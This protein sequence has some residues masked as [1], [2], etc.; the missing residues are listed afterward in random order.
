MA[1]TQNTFT[2][3][4][5]NLGPFSFTFK[6]L[7]PTDVKVTVGGVLKT[8]GTHYNLQALNY[9]TKDGGQVLFT[10]GNAPANNATIRV[11]RDTDDNA[12][13]ATFFS[14][15]AIR[16]QDLNDD[17]TQNLYSTQ[18]VKS[19]YLDRQSGEMESAYVP[20]T[21]TSLITK[22][23]METNY[24]VIDEVGFTRW[25]LAATAGQTTFSGTGNY[26]G[27]L[28][29]VPTRE[30][31]YI[32]GAL[33][34]RS[35]D[36]TA[37]NGTSVVFSVGLTVGDVVDIVCINNVVAGT[38]NNAANITYSGQF[39]G[40]TARTVAAKLADVVSVKDFGAVGDGVADDTAAIQAAFTSLLL[41]SAKTK[42]LYF[43]AGY[44]LITAPLPDITNSIFIIG[45]N[46]RDT[47]LLFSGSATPIKI[48]GSGGFCSDVCFSNIGLNG[49]SLTSGFL[50]EIDYAI[51]TRFENVGFYDPLNGVSIRQSSQ[52][53]F[54]SCIWD[55]VRGS[56]GVYAYGSGAVRTGGKLDKIDIIN[57][58]NCLLQSNW[59]PGNPAVNAELIVLDGY[60]HSVSFSGLRLLSAKR[61]FRTSNSPSLAANLV[62]RFLS[63]VGLEAE[64]HSEENFRFEA[65]GDYWINNIFSATAGKDGIYLGSSVYNFQ[66]DKG[67]IT[68]SYY[69][70]INIDGAEDTKISGVQVYYNSQVGAD[71]KSGIYIGGTSGDVQIVNSLCGKN[72][73]V[74]AY[75]EVQPFGIQ[76]ANSYTGALQVLGVE[77]TGN[78][79]GPLGLGS[80]LSTS[81]RVT[82]CIGYNP[83]GL[84]TVSVGGSPFYYTAG[85]TPETLMINGGTS[86][87]TSIGA[88]TLFTS[89]P[90]TIHLEPFQVLG[91]SYSS[92]PTI[93]ANRA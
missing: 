35:A 12:L 54:E 55:Y 9:T 71:L 70:G 47:L 21:S 65:C 88:T 1:I 45:E 7:E 8:A 34:Q 24:G 62:P 75:T 74:P 76:A 49:N 63:G 67:I 41:N 58:S 15:S 46:K 5:S 48:K 4:G 59:V 81:S 16:A 61:A 86:V 50:V 20:T 82:D 23:Y 36:Y 29:Y 11:Y 13:S 42:Q 30:Q 33:Q 69:H 43:P 2:G 85:I 10:A 73:A 77:L 83:V 37:D 25:R 57:F 51:N 84:T 44:Y 89:T 72:T 93:V 92:A 40:Q 3:N 90:C 52:V 32:N 22:G 26:G 87:T 31:V 66:I 60:V 56:Y 18:E 14:G 53:S 28:T 19:R 27:V 79:L 68:S 80:S 39:S 78:T 6:W 38:A 64:N 17:F 91:V